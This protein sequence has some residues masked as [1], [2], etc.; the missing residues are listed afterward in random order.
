MGDNMSCHSFQGKW[1]TAEEFASLSPINVFHRQ[2]DKKEI[3]GKAVENSHILFRN[4]FRVNGTG[5]VKIYISADDYYKLYINGIRA[6]QGPAPAYPQHYY[7]NEIDITEHTHIGENTIAVHTYYQGLINRVW[8][9]SD[10]RHGLILDIEENGE[11]ILKSDGSFAY[12][13]HTGYTVC[14]KVG[15]E[16]QF[17][18]RYDSSAREVGFEKGDFD[19]SYW[20]PACIRKITDYELFPQPT[21]MLQMKVIAPVSQCRGDGYITYDFGRCYVGYLLADAKGASGDKITLRFSQELDA[22]GEVRYKLRA[23]CV[24]EEEWILS[25]GDDT[26]NEF[27]YKAFQ[28]AKLIIPEGVTVSRVR[29]MARHYPFTA[30]ARPNTDDPTLLRIFDLCSG[31][32]EYG[33]QEVIQ[34]CMER[35]KGNYLG[36]GC[37]TALA[38]TVMTGDASMLKKLIDDSLRSSFVDR[39]LL[40]CAA[41]SMMQEIAEYPLMMYYAL[42]SYAVYSGDIEYLKE[43]YDAIRDVLEYYRETYEKDSGLVSDFDKWCVVEWPPNY[44]DGYDANIK[45]G[46]VCTDC[47][48]AINAHYIGALKYMNRICALIGKEEYRDIKPLEAAFI[49]AFYDKEKKLFRDRVGSEHISAVGNVFPLMYEL[50]PDEETAESIISLIDERGYDS[51]MLFGAYPFLAGLKILGKQDKIFDYIKSEKTW[52]RLLAEGATQTFE[53]WGRDTKWNT[54]LYHLTLSYALLFLTDWDKKQ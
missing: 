23:N 17:M 8:V 11:N 22:D 53:G 20:K 31:S 41:C 3:K 45:E 5:R 26:L 19:D 1:I 40:T 21:K 54:S 51:V 10:D 28:Y 42:Y 47:H 44:R 46:Q 48:V 50:Y 29:I 18:E 38:H 9:S 43:K 4:K 35:E 52:G 15:Y 12:S 6:G 14:G 27:D 7:Y 13:Y 2:L 16:T 36:D 30:V 39:G 37:Y 34:D 24:Y 32:L 33:C 49:N 25:G